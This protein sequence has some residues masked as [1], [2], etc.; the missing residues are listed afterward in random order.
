MPIYKTDKKKNG[1]LQYKVVVN[2]TDANG[3]YRQKTK[4]VYGK[5]EANL[6]EFTLLNGIKTEPNAAITLGHLYNEYIETKKH[7]VRETSLDKT[8]NVLEHHVL[9]YFEKIMLKNINVKALQK[10]KNIIS[11][12]P[13]A[14]TTK[15]NINKEFR[16]LL[17][18]GVRMEYMPNN[19]LIKLG[20]FK[21]DD[22][23]SQADKLH[24][25]T[26]EQFK[27]FIECAEARCKSLND[28]G[29]Y[30]FF[31]I[32]FFTGMRK[33]EINALKWTDIEGDIINVRRS[34]AQKVKG[35]DILE[36]PP[37][38]KSSY[39]QI[40]APKRLIDILNEHRIR[41]EQVQG[42]DASFRVC[43]GYK[44]LSDTSIANFNIAC[45]NDAGLPHI[46]V[47]DFRHTHASILVNEGINIQEIAR[48]LGHSKI[49][50]TWNTY[51]HL[52]PREEER[53]LTILNKIFK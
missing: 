38:N 36:T 6:A 7:D 43:G 11:E 39:R 24:Y 5:D 10:W 13:L 42:F 37:K 47:H 40:K 46:R 8:K 19:P 32:A 20:T 34:V 17:N 50:I 53:A 18:F 26:A 25:Y 3:K 48:R 52:Y 1:L 15:N 49:E 44:C 21:D 16:A 31:N 30:V 29:L 23:K 2:Y 35:K 45:A 4:L 51:S 41:Q 27:S 14:T 22:F 28:W 33:G 12:L 9:P